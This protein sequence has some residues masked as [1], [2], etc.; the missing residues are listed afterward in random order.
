MQDQL[1]LI[2]SLIT[3][4][5]DFPKPGVT[6]KDITPLLASPQ[7]FAASID[8][9]VASAPGDIDI[10]VGM[11]A[12]GFIFAAPVAVKLGAGFVPVRKPGKLP[13]PVF[14]E[15]FALE[16]GTETLTMHRDAI[17][18]GAR[19]MVVDDVLATGGTIGATA[20]LLRKLDV[21]LVHVA[22]VMEL[23]FLG[24]RAVLDESGI[25]SFSSILTA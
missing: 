9:I 12:R 21:N 19:V 13:R 6:F 18:S 1:S 17:P 10:V 7:G 20:K 5:P 11:E 2:Q 25:D 24:G 14:E 15:Q 3:D 23:S 22:V 4:V 16:Y 8:Q